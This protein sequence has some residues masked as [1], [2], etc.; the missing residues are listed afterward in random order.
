MEKITVLIAEDHALVR[1][2]IRALLEPTN[3][4]TVV[5]EAKNGKVAD[6]L[7]SELK[8][9]IALLDIGMPFLNG[10]E[11]A[12]LIRN[13]VPETKI[14]ILSMYSDEV[15]VIEAFDAGV[16]GYLVKDTASEELVRAIREIYDG[17]TYFS[18]K[19]LKNVI[20]AYKNTA[21]INHNNHP[22]GSKGM[23]TP[24]EREIVQLIAEGFTSNQISEKLLICIKTVKNH[25]QN[26][27]AKLDIHDVATLT[28]YAINNGVIQSN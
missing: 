20:K 10:I 16:L 2:G 1:E 11:A 27:S 15:Y 22:S 13:E 23:L 24:R 28:R 18:P 17:K 21:K 6:S 25:R 19:V 5:G 7:C 9:D 3:D 26:I 12:R 14:I 4:I 8:P